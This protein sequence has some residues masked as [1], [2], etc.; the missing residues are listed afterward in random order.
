M[1]KGIRAAKGQEA[2]GAGK[3]LGSH[4][5]VLEVYFARYTMLL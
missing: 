1:F 2:A 5:I 4:R 3:I